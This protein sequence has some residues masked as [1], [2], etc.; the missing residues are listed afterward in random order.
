MGRCSKLLGSNELKDWKDLWH[1][2]SLLYCK[3]DNISLLRAIKAEWTEHVLL[4]EQATNL[5]FMQEAE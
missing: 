5:F 4:G 1:T 2:S 3:V